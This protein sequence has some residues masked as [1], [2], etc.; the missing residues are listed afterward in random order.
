MASKKFN[1]IAAGRAFTDIVATVDHPFLERHRIPA[2]G[3]RECTTEEILQIQ[4]FLSEAQMHAGGP[5]ANTCAIVS[6]LGGSVG[7]FGK[8]HRDLAGEFFLDDARKRNIHLCC[9]PYA[10]RADMSGTCLVL[11][12]ERKRSFAYTT[13][14]SNLFSVSDFEEFNFALAE[15]F[16]LEA[17]LLTHASANHALE[18]AMRYAKKYS[19]IVINLHGITVW[20]KHH[21]IVKLIAA[22]ADVIVGND[23]EQQA[24]QDAAALLE[25]NPEQL[26][27]ITRGEHGA[28]AYQSDNVWHAPAKL[29]RKLVSTVGAGD[30]FIAGLLLALSNGES[31][32]ASLAIAI[33]VATAILSE[34]GAR[35][36]LEDFH[37]F[38][39]HSS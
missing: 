22:N 17:H 16:L 36:S 3:Q 4:N 25:K 33:N 31:V 39:Q 1:V 34:I 18:N 10:I 12:T 38:L 37:S 9:D 19:R 35:P 27:I 30:A 26:I 20:D 5:S 24:F 29:P 15:F 8:V 23:L 21:K 7:Y 32:K 13:G 28:H 11:L 2:D 14:C 6:A